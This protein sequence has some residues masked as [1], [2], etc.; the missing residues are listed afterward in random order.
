MTARSSTTGYT[1][2]TNVLVVTPFTVERLRAG[3][4][5]AAA[6]IAVVG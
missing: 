4:S 1:N 5:P 2:Q 3:T 6:N